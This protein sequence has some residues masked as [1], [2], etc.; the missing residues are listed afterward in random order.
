VEQGAHP[1]T[2]TVITQ[3]D[4][5]LTIYNPQQ[6]TVIVSHWP[7]SFVADLSFRP[8]HSLIYVYH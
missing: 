1:V 2:R 7:Q 6:L 8:T 4:L 5:A 3:H